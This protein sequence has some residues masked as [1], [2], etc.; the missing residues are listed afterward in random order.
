MST[1]R[2]ISSIS[3][4]VEVLAD[5]SSIDG[6]A[7][8]VFPMKSAAYGERERMKNTRVENNAKLTIEQFPYVGVLK[9][10]SK[11]QSLLEALS[12]V[13][14]ENWMVYY[15]VNNAA[16]LTDSS[17]TTGFSCFDTREAAISFFDYSDEIEVTSIDLLFSC[18]RINA[19]HP[20]YQ[21]PIS[22]QFKYRARDL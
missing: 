8:S 9:M 19:K 11:W 16:I 21:T 4:L 5:K 10:D 2:V 1:E 18:F 7:D 22:I 20:M 6:M 13:R 3:R 14:C 17:T 15:G 12:E